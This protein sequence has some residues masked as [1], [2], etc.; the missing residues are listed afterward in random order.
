VMELLGRANWYMP[1]WLNRIVPTLGV[2][3]DV[4]LPEHPV[5]PPDDSGMDGDRPFVSVA[6]H[7]SD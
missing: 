7:R 2:E 1:Q 3:V 4:E 5:E 6:A